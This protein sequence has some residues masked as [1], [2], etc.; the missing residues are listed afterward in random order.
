MINHKDAV[1][2]SKQPEG[3][4]DHRAVL[5]LKARYLEVVAQLEAAKH[6]NMEAAGAATV[7]Q[8]QLEATNKRLTTCDEMLQKE[9][10]DHQE[11]KAQFEAMRSLA[12]VATVDAAMKER[13]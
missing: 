9:W 4:Y 5:N 10:Q 1:Q 13:K 11:T 8:A 2:I 6:A 12:Q 7:L 3:T